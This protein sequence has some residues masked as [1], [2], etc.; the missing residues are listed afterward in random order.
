MFTSDDFESS[1]GSGESS[2]R[3][4]IG[5]YN[6]QKYAAS[7]ARRNGCTCDYVY[8][9][10]TSV[11]NISKKL[12]GEKILIDS[13]V[14]FLFSLSLFLLS[15]ANQVLKRIVVPIIL[16]ILSLLIIFYF[17]LYMSCSIQYNSG[18]LKIKDSANFPLFIII[19]TVQS[20][21]CCQKLFSVNFFTQINIHTYVRT[22]LT[23]QDYYFLFDV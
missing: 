20:K 5:S 1:F 4:L 8:G 2:M 15:Q 11:I 17:N 13:C 23:S 21:E 19:P 14:R 18:K 12:E 10:K 9:C 7:H 3:S 22:Y 6:L 16:S